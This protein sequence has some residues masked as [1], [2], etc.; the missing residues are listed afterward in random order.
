MIKGL[1]NVI[2]Y[3]LLTPQNTRFF[4]SPKKLLMIEDTETGE[5]QRAFLARAFPFE[6]EEEYLCVQNVDREEIGMIRSLSLFD[7]QTVSILREELRR[8]YF[9]PKIIRIL[10]LTERMGGSFWECE[11]DLGPLS[12]SVRDTHRSLLR[13]GADRI[14]VIDGDGCRYEIP[15]LAALDRKSYSKIE[16]YL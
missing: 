5:T 7:D 9:S 12:F 11:T 4:L 13:A 16:L 8:K 6:T 14:F 15:S 10:K 3:R 2:E 1:E